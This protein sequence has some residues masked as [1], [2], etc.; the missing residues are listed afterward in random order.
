M[1]QI[2]M[3]QLTELDDMAFFFCR[4]ILIRAGT[5][6]SQSTICFF[7]WERAA[8][9]LSYCVRLCLADWDIYLCSCLKC[10]IKLQLRVPLWFNGVLE[11]SFP[12]IWG[13][14]L[15]SSDF[16]MTSI[17][18]QWKITDHP[19]Q[20]SLAKLLFFQLMGLFVV[21]FLICKSVISVKVVLPF[22][23]VS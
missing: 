16:P 10:V 19:Q 5:D 12:M 6:N 21:F 3:Y 13:I 20:V 7:F 14:T 23:N 18:K 1:F 11:H 4:S 17:A 22:S 15:F 2:L 9:N 8:R